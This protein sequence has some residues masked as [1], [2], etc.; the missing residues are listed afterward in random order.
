MRSVL[1]EPGTALSPPGSSCRGKLTGRLPLSTAV[2]LSRALLPL[3]LP[4][5]PAPGA[6]RLQEATAAESTGLPARAEPREAIQGRAAA[7]AAEAAMALRGA[8]LLLPAPPA[9]S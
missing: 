3:L 2:T 6:A 8:L 7:A 5:L 9:P 4:P 1:A